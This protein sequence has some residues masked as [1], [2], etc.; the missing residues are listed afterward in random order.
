MGKHKRQAP[1][2]TEWLFAVAAPLT[3]LAMLI[4]AL[5]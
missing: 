4:T 2:V 3:A 1:H 5:R